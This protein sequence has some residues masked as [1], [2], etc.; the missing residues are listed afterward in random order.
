MR[1]RSVLRVLLCVIL[2]SST[3]LFGQENQ[4]PAFNLIRTP[5]SP[6][7]VMLGI[8]PT[9]VE[10]PN[11]PAS[12][13]LSVLN[14]TNTFSQLPQNYALELSPYWL[15]PH[16]RLTWRQDTTRSIIESLLR[17]GTVSVATAQLGS[18]VLPVT[19]FSAGL[20]ASLISGTMTRTAINTLV[21]AESL[22]AV[23]ASSFNRRLDKALRETHLDDLRERALVEAGEDS[24]RI[25][26]VI[27][28]YAAIEDS[29]RAALVD[30][31]L[32]SSDADEELAEALE[33][34]G[35]REG[36]ALEGA[37][38]LTWQYP[39]MVVDSVRFSRFGVWLTPSYQGRDVSVIGVVR[40]MSDELEP[41]MGLV[42]IG[43]RLLYTHEL[44]AVSGEYVHR[45]F[46]GNGGAASQRRI[47]GI[48]EYRVLQ[49]VWLQAAIGKDFDPSAAGSLIARLGLSFQFG[50]QRY[51]P[52]VP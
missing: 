49:D 35:E 21:M 19:G 28:R 39:R 12:L 20:R 37:V 45:I 51:A 26:A 27:E 33:G 10:R 47:S 13:G 3:R 32:V 36:F 29:I 34:A 46:T 16:P 42:D 9:A 52:P 18:E 1:F 17:T 14:T 4:P 24:M 40:F 6:A 43:G 2:F 22:L 11:T 5:T 25:V 44:F 38:G 41:S 50:R 7:F 48:V 23:Q 8:A 30:G 15:L 31:S